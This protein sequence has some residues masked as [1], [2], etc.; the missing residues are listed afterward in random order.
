MTV[1][2]D[3]LVVGQRA[4]VMCFSDT[5]VVE[6]IEWQRGGQVVVEATSVQH[7]QLVLDPVSDTDSRIIVTCVVTRSGQ[8]R[9]NQSLTLF[10]TGKS[11]VIAMVDLSSYS[12]H[13]VPPNSLLANAAV[14]GPP[15]AG[16]EF[17][18]DCIISENITG[19]TNMPTAMWVVMEESMVDLS[20]NDDITIT[21]LRNDTAAVATITFD[22]LRASHGEGGE[23]Y[24]CVG[25]L[26]T[27]AVTVTPGLIEVDREEPLTVQSKSLN[28]FISM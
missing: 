23:V 15:V 8:G 26:M 16:S 1:S 27:A 5:G 28:L 17:S 4:V 22:P 6:R 25:T 2:S 3:L 20:A 11:I 21:T 7:L 9:V 13:T 10:V 19:L 24:R 14:S 18:M 12:L